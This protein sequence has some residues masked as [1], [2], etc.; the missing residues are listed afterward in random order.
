M[1]E[2]MY[3]DVQFEHINEKT[4]RGKVLYFSTS[5]VSEVLDVRDSKIRYY[6]NEFMDLFDEGDIVIANTQKKYTQRAIDKLKYFIQL[7][8]KGMTIKQIKEYCQEI[9]I[10]EDNEIIIPHSA[11][12]PIQAIALAVREQTN[13]D[14][15]LFKQELLDTLIEFQQN[16][17]KSIEEYK[18]QI[19]KD[20]S[21]T[22]DEVISDKIEQF[23]QEFIEQQQAE[24]ELALR[25]IDLVNDLNAK[26]DQKKEEYESQKN[27][28]FLRRLF[29]R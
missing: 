5:Q 13:Q 16:Q 4:I 19:L 15:V 6:T 1:K 14:M 29:N 24:K 9:E 23:K 12:L 26:L 20:I 2:D 17:Q 7:K 25:T 28:R 11:P 3:Y 8:N 22:V 21:L 27:K 18:Q 10:D